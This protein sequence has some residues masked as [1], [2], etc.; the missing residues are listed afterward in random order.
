[1]LP[2]TVPTVA[3][4]QPPSP[5]T[6]PQL[7]SYQL[8]RNRF[9]CH[10]IGFDPRFDILDGQ[11]ITVDYGNG[12]ILAGLDVTSASGRVTLFVLALKASG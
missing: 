1:V 2:M 10:R 11:R 8:V 5:S 12:A 4:K 6:F 7:H 9:D 3:T